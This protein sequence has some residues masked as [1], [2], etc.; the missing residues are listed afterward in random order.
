MPRTARSASWPEPVHVE[1]GALHL[2]VQP[3]DLQQVLGQPAH[4]LHTLLDH[5]GGPPRRQQLGGRVQPGQRGA[6][7]MGH[8]GGEALLAVQLALQARGH[9]VERGGHGG[10]LVPGVLGPLRA[11]IVHPGVEVTGADTAGHLRGAVQTPGDA[12]GGVQA[13]DEGQGD[14]DG[15]RPDDGLVQAADDGR[16]LAVVL[17]DGQ[18][19]PVGR[20]HRPH[21]RA[22]V[23]L[24]ELG[25]A[26]A[27][28]CHVPQG[29]RQLRRVQ[30]RVAAERLP[31][32]VRRDDRVQPYQCRVPGLVLGLPADQDVD[33]DAEHRG[34]ETAH[35]HDEQGG[36]PAQ[37]RRPG[38]QAQPPARAVTGRTGAH[39][40]AFGRAGAVRPDRTGSNSIA[41]SSMACARSSQE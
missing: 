24:P 19:L 39:R 4:G 1:I 2:R 29:G 3:G 22:A 41:R 27:P 28:P 17:A 5:L 30:A 37:R 6:Q 7:L 15:R 35:D 23:P 14:R 10:G 38:R 16:P 26:L 11:G 31:G 20:S 36:L 40:A 33:E 34:Q 21:D 12:P 32:H 18:R 9:R 8:I 25:A 13:D